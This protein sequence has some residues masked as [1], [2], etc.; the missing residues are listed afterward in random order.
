MTI[1]ILC[2]LLYE[3]KGIEETV[4]LV[5]MCHTSLA[6]C[7]KIGWCSFARTL[8]LSL[9]PCSSLLYLCDVRV[10]VRVMV[11]PYVAL[12][13]DCLCRW[14]AYLPGVATSASLQRKRRT[15]VSKSAF[16]PVSV[17]Q[18]GC[19]PPIK[20]VCGLYHPYGLRMGI[21]N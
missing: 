18:W 6:R 13:V 20:E 16:F 14:R 9:C 4:T 15:S 17:R 19:I 12:S 3:A 5:H 1:A 21:G 7:Q 10:C 2:L 11:T 8:S